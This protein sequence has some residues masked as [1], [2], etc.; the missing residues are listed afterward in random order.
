M[1][2]KEFKVNEYITLKL[3]QEK[4]KLYIKGEEFLQ[5]KYLLL[6]NPHNKEN[7]VAINSIDEASELLISDLERKVT[8]EQIGL[9][10]SDEFWGHSSNLQAWAEHDYDTRLL[11]SNLSFHLLKRLM[12]LGD[13]KASRMYKN[14]LAQRYVSGSE[15]VRREI[16]SL[17]YLQSLTYEELCVLYEQT[18]KTYESFEIYERIIENLEEG[19]Y[20]LGEEGKLKFK[21]FILKG[22]N[23]GSIK[24]KDYILKKSLLLSQNYDTDD[25][26][27]SDEEILELYKKIIN[28]LDFNSLI[29]LIEDTRK[30]FHPYNELNVNEGKIIGISIKN[31]YVNLLPESI[32]DFKNLVYLGFGSQRMDNVPPW[33]GELKQ[34]KHLSLSNLS[35]TKLPETIGDLR[36]L[37]TLSITHNNK[38]TNVPDS[39]TKLEKVKYLDLSFNALDNIPN[40]IG[41][42][43]ELEEINLSNNNIKEIPESLSKC[44]NLKKL[45]IHNN[46]IKPK[47][48]TEL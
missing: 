30:M 36:N 24:L 6:I 25:V 28:K 38:L 7:H 12:E 9:T 18:T 15:G 23:E 47:E 34:I 33:I 29:K 20:K 13:L 42:L 31:P 1:A 17:G 40:S 21:E 19:W 11:H 5:C 32:K 4:T 26:L 39:I 37:E 8:L 41:D 16:Y 43:R 48:N 2:E 35:A 3:E 44:S 27:F 45:V 22:F 10:P 46:K 14:E